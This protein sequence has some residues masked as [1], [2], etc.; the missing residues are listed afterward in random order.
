MDPNTT[1]KP[2]ELYHL[3]YNCKCPLGLIVVVDL[4]A[5]T[6]MLFNVIVLLTLYKYNYI[7]KL[8]VQWFTY[9]I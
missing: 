8:N 5:D 2:S 3:L 1:D 7:I 4:S 9:M 6:H